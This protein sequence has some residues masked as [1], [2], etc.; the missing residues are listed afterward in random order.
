LGGIR[1]RGTFRGFSDISKRASFG[2]RTPLAVT[3]RRYAPPHRTS[4]PLVK[5]VFPPLEFF[6]L[7]ATG[8]NHA[9]SCFGD[10]HGNS[11]FETPCSLRVGAGTTHLKLFRWTTS[12]PYPLLQTPR[13]SAR[14]PYV[15]CGALPK[16]S[17][18][19][20]LLSASLNA[21]RAA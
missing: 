16:M 3:T 8:P 6:R 18:R 2:P 10:R 7:Q 1:T 5:N 17:P 13:G 4:R 20:S 19:R 15:F 9:L 11:V 14:A 12:C 21:R